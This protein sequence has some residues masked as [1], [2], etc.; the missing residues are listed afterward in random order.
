MEHTTRK[1]A[2]TLIELLVVI[3]IISVLAAILFPVFAR[4]RENARRTSC[5][6]NMKQLGLGVMMYVQDYDERFFGPSF[7]SAGGVEET[8]PCP[9]NAA[10]ACRSYWPVKLYPYI[11]NRQVFS[12]PSDTSSQGSW[13]G[14][15]NNAATHVGYGYNREFNN[16]V[17]LA[18]VDKA[19]QTALLADSEGWNRYLLYRTGY[20]EVSPPTS[21]N[22]VRQVPDRHLNGAVFVFADGHAKW[23]GVKR[24]PTIPIRTIQPGVE[25]GVYYQPDGVR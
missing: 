22:Q 16:S 2:F 8:L 12:C 3:A 21:V 25:Q 19:S 4:A 6:S 11:K 7:G 14:T 23:F 17:V 18:A 13:P 24:N 5:L 1:R 15:P 10:Q 9:G 20:A